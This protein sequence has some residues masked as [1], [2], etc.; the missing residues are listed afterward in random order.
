MPFAQ[1]IRERVE[2]AGG[3]NALCVSL[4]FDE[5]EILENNLEYLKNT[6]DV[7]LFKFKKKMNLSHKKKLNYSWKL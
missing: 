7:S 2:T 3:K 6:L 5:K 1:M 4:D